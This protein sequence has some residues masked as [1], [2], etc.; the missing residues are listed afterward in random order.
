MR[1]QTHQRI[2]PTIR[3][4]TRASIS[5]AV[6]K[7]DPIVSNKR[8]KFTVSYALRFNSREELAGTVFEEKSCRA[9]TPRSSMPTA[10]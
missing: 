5:N 6:L 10:P 1:A 2:I 3:R 7:I 8:R 4:T 9:A